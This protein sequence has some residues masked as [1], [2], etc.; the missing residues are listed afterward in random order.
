M[1]CVVCALQGL[2]AAED[3]HTKYTP[4]TIVQLFP[5]PMRDDLGS[6]SLNSACNHVKTSAGVSG[7]PQDADSQTAEPEEP[8]PVNHHLISL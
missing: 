5:S 8:T 7:L 6:L 2:P 1:Y 4:D 3:P